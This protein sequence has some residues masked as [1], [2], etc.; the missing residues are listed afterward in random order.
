M[1]AQERNVLSSGE[2][3]RALVLSLFEDRMT[4]ILGGIGTSIAALLTAVATGSMVLYALTG[5]MLL[6]SGARYGVSWLFINRR[7]LRS[8]SNSAA[9]RW[10]NLYTIG[11]VTMTSLLGFWCIYCHLVLNHPFASFAS[12]AV[13]FANLVGISGRNFAM[14][15]LVDWQIWTAGGGMVVSIVYADVFYLALAALMLPFVLSIRKIAARQRETLNRA[16][17]ERRH[18]RHLAEQMDT[19][20]NNIP[21]CICMFDNLARLEVAN[22]Q[23]C[24][25]FGI[26]RNEINRVTFAELINLIAE[27]QFIPGSDLSILLRTV[28]TSRSAEVN[29]RFRMGRENSRIL[30]LCARPTRQGGVIATFEDVTREEHDA[31]RIERLERF[32]RL[33]G[34]INR[35]ELIT[36]LDRESAAR[37][38]GESCAVLLVNLNR[39]SEVND[40]LGYRMGDALLIETTNRLGSILPAGFHLARYGG[41]E[42][43]IVMRG[44]NADQPAVE[45]AKRI[46]E[47]LDVPYKLEKRIIQVGCRVGISVGRRLEDTA[48][49]LLK[50]ADMALFRA[51]GDKNNGWMMFDRSM[52]KELGE[53]R[54][55]EADL[56]AA[57]DRGQFE[58][59]FQPIVSLKERRVG[60]CEA[61]L[62]WRHPTSGFISPAD[63]IP[64]AEETGQITAIGEWMLF[65]SCS[66]C[67]RWPGDVGVAV[68]LSPVQFRSGNVVETVR[69]VLLRTGLEPSRLE[70]EITESLMLENLGDTISKLRELKA[71]GVSISLDDF[72][73]GY[74]SLSNVN[75]LPLD[76]LKI[77]G[78]FVE[79]LAEKSKSLTLVQAIS[80]MGEQLGLTVVIEGVEKARQ[81]DLIMNETRV[82]HVQGYY[83]SKPLPET[84][85]LTLLAA[86]DDGNHPIRRQFPQEEAA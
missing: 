85:I 38:S 23:A 42:F 21:D 80:S 67:S 84:E 11:A 79:D 26:D 5:V 48:E 4:L 55:L 29:Y 43:A 18:A 76:K 78:S 31:N 59:H 10:E 68:N 65:E 13:T 62:R 73:T 82:T 86:P 3:Y 64:I 16:F 83:F 41:D 74:S 81:L 28:Q 6:I 14:Q 2:D 63:F 7:H 69:S 52:A 71:I 39:F 77:D 15:R 35:K 12:V 20:L 60:V 53:R 27:R 54:Q 75:N 22:I 61:L 58:A 25:M 36:V 57:L 24:E 34:L 32:D 51:K 47:V 49:L 19:T 30:R 33:T 45:L 40:L 72:G 66:A 46:I 1:E 56:K 44:V 9:R 17:S 8:W 37:K 70:L 50:Q